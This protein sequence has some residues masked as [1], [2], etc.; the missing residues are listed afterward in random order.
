[1]DEIKR[2]KE[3]LESQVKQ[4][5]LSGSLKQKGSTRTGDEEL[6]LSNSEF[7]SQ[8]D[9]DERMKEIMEEKERLQK[10]RD[11]EASQKAQMQEMIKDL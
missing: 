5:S 3:M 4:P 9:G 1:M 8:D 6:E 10:E 11:Q 7:L 2:L